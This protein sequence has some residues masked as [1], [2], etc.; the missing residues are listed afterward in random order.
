M[1]RATCPELASL[2]HSGLRLLMRL[3]DKFDLRRP[4]S[5]QALA[6]TWFVDG[7]QER[8]DELHTV[9]SRCSATDDAS[10]TPVVDHAAVLRL[11]RHRAHILQS[12]LVEDSGGPAAAQDSPCGSHDAKDGVSSDSAMPLG[13]D[14]RINF[15]SSRV[16]DSS[17]SSQRPFRSPSNCHGAGDLP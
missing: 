9:S 16:E 10:S 6:E 5:A 15:H 12:R 8:S 11:P 4:T 2:S 14:E 7:L 3:L 13:S 1:D 17:S